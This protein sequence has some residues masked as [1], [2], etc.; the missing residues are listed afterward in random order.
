[1]VR[2]LASAGRLPPGENPLS[3]ENLAG[4]Y[5]FY[6][7]DS[8]GPVTGASSWYGPDSV[9]M[10]GCT[11]GCN[12]TLTLT[13]QFGD[14]WSTTVNAPPYHFVTLVTG[15][16]TKTYTLTSGGNQVFTIPV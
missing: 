13:D 16:R 7:K 5:D 15:A 6:V 10:P 9:S 4:A 8:C 11:N 2:S 14:G 12:Y 1:V 3:W